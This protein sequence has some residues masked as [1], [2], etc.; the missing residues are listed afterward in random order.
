[1]E[2][3]RTTMKRSGSLYNGGKYYN[4]EYMTV[5][6]HPNF[7]SEN[8]EIGNLTYDGQYYW[9][10]EM[11]YNIHRDILVIVHYDED[12]FYT[13]LKPQQQKITRFQILD[14]T[15][16]RINPDTLESKTIREGYY[17]MLYEGDSK[18]LLKHQKTI[19]TKESASSRRDYFK[20]KTR[21][22]VNVNSNYYQIRGKRSL[23]KALVSKE[24]DIKSFIRLNKL[25]FADNPVEDTIMTLKYFDGN[26]AQL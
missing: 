1:M 19:E 25:K 6:G 14:Q 2:L 20:D 23:L 18:V 22:F 9:N 11:L 26:D 16:I 12:G 24:K 17:Q 10:I 5:K 13:E 4:D 8:P 3:Y 7:E 21:L 15:F